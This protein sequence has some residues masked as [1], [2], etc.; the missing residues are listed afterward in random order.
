[1]IAYLLND[2]AAAKQ[3][4]HLDSIQRCYSECVGLVST[5]MEELS[6][7]VQATLERVFAA[8]ERMTVDSART[9]AADIHDI[10]EADTAFEAHFSGGE[11]QA[12]NIG[13][14]GH[15]ERLVELAGRLFLETKTSLE[16]ELAKKK[17]VS[18]ALFQKLDVMAC[19]FPSEFGGAINNVKQ[20]MV[21][22]AEDVN[23]SIAASVK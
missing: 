15:G 20:T 12:A 10:Q 4:I 9:I 19:V 17:Q 6:G 13:G 7:N 5:R 2:L 16:N 23:A 22:A 11:D 1:M 14:G 21:V 3:M 8:G 18:G